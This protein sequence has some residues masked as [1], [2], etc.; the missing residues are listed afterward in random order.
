MN[1]V[2]TNFQ[3]FDV[4]CE[5]LSGNAVSG[6]AGIRAREQI[7][8]IAEIGVLCRWRAASHHDSNMAE[9][10]HGFR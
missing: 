5:S 6:I 8:P 7:F 4:C 3:L 10:D 9:L 2:E 1:A